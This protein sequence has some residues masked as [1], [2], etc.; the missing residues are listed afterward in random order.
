M[1]AGKSVNFQS[2][3]AQTI[4]ERKQKCGRCKKH[5]T[6]ERMIVCEAPG[7]GQLYHLSCVH[8]AA[9]PS[10]AWH[11]PSCPAPPP[12]QSAGLDD[13]LDRPSTD[14]YPK[15]DRVAGHLRGT[16]LHFGEYYFY[17]A[18]ENDTPT[19]I[20]KA[21]APL[22]PTDPALLRKLQEEQMVPTPQNIVCYNRHHLLR[23]T[24]NSKL[25]DGTAVWILVP[26]QGAPGKNLL[27]AFGRTPAQTPPP[28]G[29]TPPPNDQVSTISI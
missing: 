1:L 17:I 29:Q 25:L 11:C 12:R 10:G 20:A 28:H 3:A 18:R 14:S 16:F 8:L 23:I 13:T 6:G 19:T 21:I 4:F 7:C 5:A 22:W 27:R 24:A 2:D 15:P 9:E 26:P